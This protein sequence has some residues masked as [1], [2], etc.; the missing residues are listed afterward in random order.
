M[1][2]GKGTRGLML[3][4]V[5]LVGAL[6]FL[7]LESGP[8]HL[9]WRLP[10]EPEFF[11][12]VVRAPQGEQVSAA[13]QRLEATWHRDRAYVL[14]LSAL[15]RQGHPRVR[16]L[17]RGVPRSFEVEWLNPWEDTWHALDQ[18]PQDLVQ[19]RVRREQDRPD[20]VRIDFGPPGGAA[21]EPGMFRAVWFRITPREAGTFRFDLAG[22]A[23]GP[24]G[25][26][27]EN[28]RVT[29]RLS[30]IIRVEEPD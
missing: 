23:V 3:L 19:S 4:V 1:P 8:V 29:P 14:P 5:L 15:G 11:P 28:A 10:P 25:W 13:G 24:Q 2:R 26:A 18:L 7:Y 6:I 9:S 20:R 27:E 22:H 12:G 17:A 21:F 30:A 16:Y